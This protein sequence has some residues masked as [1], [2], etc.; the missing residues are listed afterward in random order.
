MQEHQTYETCIINSELWHQESLMIWKKKSKLD[1]HGINIIQLEDWFQ[2]PNANKYTNVSQAMNRRFLAFPNLFEILHVWAPNMSETEV[3][4][5]SH[6]HLC[7]TDKLYRTFGAM[8]TRQP[9]QNVQRLRCRQFISSTTNGRWADTT[10]NKITQKLLLAYQ[11]VGRLQ[12]K[13]KSN[14]RIQDLKIPDTV[15]EYI[16][17]VLVQ[18]GYTDIHL[19][20]NDYWKSLGLTKQRIQLEYTDIFDRLKNNVPP[21][22]FITKIT[23]KS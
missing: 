3:R 5:V 16:F 17:Y 18:I 8:I 12:P 13:G 9:L 4:M 14:V 20:D 2:Y 22:D 11:H 23:T 1:E 10:T 6:V 19:L 7:L 15:V 21:R